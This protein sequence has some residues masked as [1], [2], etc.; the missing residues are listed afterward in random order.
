MINS[1]FLSNNQI[2]QQQ[3]IQNNKSIAYWARLR[4]LQLKNNEYQLLEQKKKK[5]LSFI[6]NDLFK[7]KS[8][9]I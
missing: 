4:N 9:L 5:F 1:K 7:I 8:K 6:F 3:L 2:K